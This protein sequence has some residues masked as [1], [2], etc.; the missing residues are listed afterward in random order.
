MSIVKE[1]GTGSFRKTLFNYSGSDLPTV[2]IG[3]WVPVHQELTTWGES[4]EE[5]G[6]CGIQVGG[7]DSMDN[8]SVG[9]YFPPSITTAG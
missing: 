4:W 2:Y 5:T 1:P 6:R 8:Q 3:E 7:M 9:G